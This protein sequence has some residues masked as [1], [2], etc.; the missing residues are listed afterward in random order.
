MFNIL[1][2]C[3]NIYIQCEQ[4]IF[5]E[6]RA[7][8]YLHRMQLKIHTRHIHNC[9]SRA[10]FFF[11]HLR[12]LWHTHKN[13]NKVS[14]NDVNCAG[15]ARFSSSS[16]CFLAKIQRSTWSWVNEWAAWLWIICLSRARGHL[17][18][19]STTIDRFSNL[20]HSPKWRN[21]FR[22]KLINH[23]PTTI[24]MTATTRKNNERNHLT[25]HREIA[26]HCYILI[27]NNLHIHCIT[28]KNMSNRCHCNK[29]S[30]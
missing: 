27:S 23:S 12:R 15:W 20:V 5:H 9:T 3:F 22:I 11:F 24:T 16:I 7:F 2:E 8:H 6:V 28:H 1:C 4:C 14:M 19:K 26:L 21:H 18:L 29:N 25:A 30:P 13:N 17:P 10:L